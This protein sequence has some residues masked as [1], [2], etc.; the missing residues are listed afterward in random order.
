L[1]T[2]DESTNDYWVTRVTKNGSYAI[3]DVAHVSFPA[4]ALAFDGKQ[5]WTNHREADQIVSFSL[6]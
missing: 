6:P 2:E 1:T 3:D 4:R 5:F